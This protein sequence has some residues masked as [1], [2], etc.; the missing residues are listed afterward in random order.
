MNEIKTMTQICADAFAERREK[1]DRLSKLI[2]IVDGYLVI[3]VNYE[4]NI[5]L[6]RCDTYEKIV[7]WY[8]HLHDKPW[9]SDELMQFFIKTALSHHN[10]SPE[11]SM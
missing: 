6:D 8:L 3:D 9:M 1:Y 10:L 7:G 11:G 4:Y 2:Y 5:G